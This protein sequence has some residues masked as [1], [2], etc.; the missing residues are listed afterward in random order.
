[1]RH[2]VVRSLDNYEF[3]SL[4]GTI[5]TLGER[6]LVLRH[7]LKLT[8]RKLAE[9]AEIDKNTIAR[10][11]R[12]ELQDLAGAR[13]VALARVLGVSGNVLLGMEPLDSELLPTLVGMA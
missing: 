11:E 13:I 3:L 9:L 10:L 4:E 12:G 1:L 6:V 7:R 8:Q 2:E 5:M